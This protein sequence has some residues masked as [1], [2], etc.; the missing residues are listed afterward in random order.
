MRKKL[1]SLFLSAL[2]ISAAFGTAVFA[3]EVDTSGE[4]VD[5]TAE[6]AQDVL[7]G[8]YGDISGKTINF[9]ENVDVVLD[10]ARPTKYEGSKTIYYNQTGDDPVTDISSLS[11]HARYFR[12]LEDVKFT[13]D[14]GITVAGFTYSAGH[15]A[16]SGYDYVKDI[17]QTTGITYYD[18]RSLN[19]IT[20]EN[21]TIK[22]EADF[23]LYAF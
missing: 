2:L 9:T 3:A 18:F 6:T 11:N 14:E 5:V 23:K 20:F 22:D 10:L 16:S 4:I 15:V 1:L 17:E 21:L 12:T 13:A 8:R 19:N 7:D